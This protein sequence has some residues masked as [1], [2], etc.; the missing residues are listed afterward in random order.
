MI[1]SRLSLNLENGKALNEKLF[2]REE[3]AH[4]KDRAIMQSRGQGAALTIA[5]VPLQRVRRGLSFTV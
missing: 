5:Y 2:E 4:G 1:T 3:N